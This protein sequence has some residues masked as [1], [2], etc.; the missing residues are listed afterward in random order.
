MFIFSIVLGFLA[1]AFTLRIAY[2]FSRL[3]S[4]PIKRL[5]KGMEKVEEGNFDFE[6]EQNSN[7]EL[8]LLVP[9]F[10]KM[11]LFFFYLLHV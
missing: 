8:G 3:I 10:N 4:S 1:I 7:D 2:V 11:V 6:L 5:Q 9:K